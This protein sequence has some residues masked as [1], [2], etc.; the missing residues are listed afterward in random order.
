MTPRVTGR[1]ARRAALLTV[2]GGAAFG[3]RRAT[4]DDPA[5]SDI[6]ATLNRQATARARGDRD[7]F[8]ATIDQ[9]NLTWRRIQGDAFTLESGRGQ[10]A[11]L[12]YW[13]TGTQAKQSGY[14]K[15]WIDIGAQDGAALVGQAVWVFRQAESGWLHS[16]ILNEEIGPRKSQS[17]EHFTLGHFDWDDDVIERMVGVAER[18]HAHVTARTGI[19]PAGRP[20][21]S[22]NPTYGAHSAL[23]GYG[24]WAL[25]LPGTD[26]I[27]IRSIES[28]GAGITAPG[29]TQEDRL[30]V[31]LTHEY[32][33]LVNNS[34][35]PTVKMPK[36]MVEGF[37]EFV[38]SHLR[39]G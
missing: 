27:V 12:S 15:A 32:A 34:V 20:A 33:H 30:L 6:Q 19:V 16:E 25:F 8:M 23:R 35:V 4:A 5:T 29:E 17:S 37:A 22:V 3:V 2:L 26:Q 14:V 18:A 11:A 24:T 38:T 1:F 21:I 7:A 28:Y 13:V 39:E 10:R 9:R 36:W 31:A